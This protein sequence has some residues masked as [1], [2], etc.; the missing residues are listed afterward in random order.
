MSTVS[1]EYT[2]SR[3]EGLSRVSDPVDAMAEHLAEAQRET[4]IR[5]NGPGTLVDIS[6]DAVT[7][8]CWRFANKG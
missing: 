3:S 1:I 8:G 2:G 5:P 4:W 6:P 7:A